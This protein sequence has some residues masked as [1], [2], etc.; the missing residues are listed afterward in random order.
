MTHQPEQAQGERDIVERLKS[1]APAW[2]IIGPI[3]IQPAIDEILSLRTQLAEKEKKFKQL[4]EAYISV[5]AESGKR[6]IE[7]H[8]LRLQLAAI[9]K[10]TVEEWQLIETAPKDGS[11]IV[12]AKY[13]QES[14]SNERPV[15]WWL[16]QGLWSS[17]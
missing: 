17:K 1:E 8:K 10:Q 16:T 14:G 2:A 6:L 9:R 3:L 15:L 4:H 12:L 5:G 7:L 11:S 13:H